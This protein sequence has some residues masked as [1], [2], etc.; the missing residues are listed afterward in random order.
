[1]KC[2]FAMFHEP[3]SI[4]SALTGS[5]FRFFWAGTCLS[6]QSSEILQTLCQCMSIYVSRV[7]LIVSLLFFVQWFQ[8]KSIFPYIKEKLLIFSINMTLGLF[9]LKA[10][11]SATFCE[12]FVDSISYNVDFCFR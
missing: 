8:T 7:L 12:I 11:I 1:M 9:Y 2:D 4:F 10:T 6:A 5:T 3:K